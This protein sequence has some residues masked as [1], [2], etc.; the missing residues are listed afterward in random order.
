MQNDRE[1]NNVL[2]HQ[3]A[4]DTMN[5]L[6]REFEASIAGLDRLRDENVFQQQVGRFSDRLQHHLEYIAQELLEQFH[7]G[8]DRN[9]WNQ[10]LTQFIHGYVQE[11]RQKVQSR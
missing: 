2:F 8:A 3:R 1:R 11:F 4:S 10:H 7:T 6:F 9:E 5:H